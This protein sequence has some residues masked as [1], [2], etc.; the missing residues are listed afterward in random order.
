MTFCHQEVKKAVDLNVVLTYSLVSGAKPMISFPSWRWTNHLRFFN[1]L[2]FTR[3][4]GQ[5][6]KLI[7]IPRVY[8]IFWIYSKPA[9]WLHE[10]TKDLPEGNTLLEDVYERYIAF[11]S[12][13]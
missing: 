13:Q 10:S 3:N 11:K 6:K 7:Y 12:L 1:F 4:V 2:D 9:A 8:E 5:M